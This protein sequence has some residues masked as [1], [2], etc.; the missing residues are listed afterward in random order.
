MQATERPIVRSFRAKWI[1]EAVKHV[2]AGG[3]AVVWETPSRVRLVFPMPDAS[4]VGDLG[5][6]S[7]YDIGK[8]RWTR[9]KKGPYKGFGSAIVPKD[10]HEIV[11]RRAERD[12]I[13]KGAVRKVRFDCLECG[14]CCRDN[15]VVLE[16][17]D[18]ERLEKAG[19]GALARAPYAKKKNGRVVLTLLAS[20]RCRH[21]ARDNKCKI[22]PARPDACS[23]FPVASE[24][25]MF[26]REEEFGWVDGYRSPTRERPQV[27]QLS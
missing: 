10:C 24:C 18:V 15:E 25:C 1:R 21:L 27:I 11:T 7:I 19:K 26:A 16:K 13:F 22:Y 4:D 20:K 23:S 5:A 6:W 8:E 2:A 17:D 3:H 14:A 9:N 12:S